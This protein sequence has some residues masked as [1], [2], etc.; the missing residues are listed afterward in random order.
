MSDLLGEM[1]IPIPFIIVM[2][3]KHN[4]FIGSNTNKDD[5]Y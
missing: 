3:E 2:N 5:S 1:D 4:K